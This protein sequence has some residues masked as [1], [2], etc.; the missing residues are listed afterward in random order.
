MA[1]LIGLRYI[2][3]SHRFRSRRGAVCD[4][5]TICLSIGE[6]LEHTLFTTTQKGGKLQAPKASGAG[7]CRWKV[8]EQKCLSTYSLFVF[9]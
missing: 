5:K 3:S 7:S 1:S 9:G 6:E 8:S 4:R 2:S